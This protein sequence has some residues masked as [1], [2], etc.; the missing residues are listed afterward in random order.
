MLEILSSHSRPEAAGLASEARARILSRSAAEASEA[1]R[2]RAG[3]VS[4][5]EV[6]EKAEQDL[7]S[8]M[9]PLL[10]RSI[11][12]LTK[13][14][15]QSHLQ[16]RNSEWTSRVHVL[17]RVFLAHLHDADSYVFLAAVQGLVALADGSPDMAIALV[18]ALRDA[19]DSLEARIKL[20]EA[21]LF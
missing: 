1:R 17:A 21:L 19:S 3:K 16:S 8:E 18:K 13:V 9:V 5:E 6:L 14:V 12:T 15:R 10:A 7:L 20:S 2:A 4:F 11:V